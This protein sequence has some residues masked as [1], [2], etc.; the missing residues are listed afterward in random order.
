LNSDCDTDWVIRAVGRV[1]GVIQEYVFKTYK[2]QKKIVWDIGNE[3]Y[4]KD[5]WYQLLLTKQNEEL[6]ELSWK[7]ALEMIIRFKIQ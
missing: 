1:V 2:T 5:Y 7:F 3:R 4:T 6:R